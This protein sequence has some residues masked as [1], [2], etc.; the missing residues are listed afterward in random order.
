[1]GRFVLRS[2]LTVCCLV[3]AL[4]PGWCSIVSA[5]VA[6]DKEVPPKK[7]HSGCCDLCH[8]KDR[9]KPS[10]EPKQPAP[11]SRCCC[12]ELDWLKPNPPVTAQADLSLV[13]FVTPLDNIPTVAPVGYD[14]DLSIP[15]PSPPLHVLKCVWLC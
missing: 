12:Y 1:M 15:V 10:P 14:L 9:E 2:L 8:C 11:P 6:R 5:P 7:A 3:L 13:A 4:P